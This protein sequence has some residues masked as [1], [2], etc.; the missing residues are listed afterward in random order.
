ME[1][2]MNFARRLCQMGLWFG[3][4][5]VMAAILIRSDVILR[6]V[7][8]T[9]IGVADELVGYALALGTTGSLGAARV[10]GP[11]VG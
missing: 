6:K 9:S 10:M 4:T 1:R 8:K 5:L 3:G 11:L 7:F 2:V